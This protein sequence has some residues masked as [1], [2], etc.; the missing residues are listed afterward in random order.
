MVVLLVTV[1]LGWRSVEAEIKFYTLLTASLLF[2]SPRL[3]YGMG[4]KNALK[5]DGQ[6]MHNTR[7][8]P[9]TCTHT[10]P[11]ACEIAEVKNIKIVLNVSV[12][13]KF[14]SV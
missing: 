11:V 6:Y 5:L 3:S 9:Y 13:H 8:V 12:V 2:P 10:H 7:L 4:E 1:L 14:N